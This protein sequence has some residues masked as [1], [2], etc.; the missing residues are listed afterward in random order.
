MELH[1]TAN[2]EIRETASLA[3]LGA[4]T[5]AEAAEFENHRAICTVCDAE[6][7]AFAA[8]GAEL[9]F[10]VPEATPSP[11]VRRSLLRRAGGDTAVPP[12]VL[13]R[14][15]EGAWTESGF[16]GV[17]LRTMF[18]DPT[19]GAVTSLVRMAPGAVYPAHRHAGPEHC[20][21]LE[22]DLVFEDHVLNAGDYEVA[23]PRSD[24]SFVTTSGGCLLLLISHVNDQLRPA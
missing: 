20:Y 9:A 16:P 24:H 10:S 15:N 1:L 13:M 6:Y 14:S 7:R 4:L 2:E 23:S 8:A 22:G 19:S 5:P 21:V 11:E 18:Q 3:V 17:A 12:F